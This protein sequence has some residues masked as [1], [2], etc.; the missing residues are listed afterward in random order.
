[1]RF[2][3]DSWKLHRSHYGSFS[4]PL[5]QAK[6]LILPGRRPYT[7]S[8]ASWI[9]KSPRF[10]NPRTAYKSCF[11][12]RNFN[13]SFLNVWVVAVPF[14]CP[15]YMSLD[16][17]FYVCG[18]HG[19]VMKSAGNSSS[20]SFL[21]FPYV[22]HCKRMVTFLLPLVYFYPRPLTFGDLNRV[23]FQGKGM[24]ACAKFVLVRRGGTSVKGT[25]AE[26]WL[27][28]YGARWREACD[29][30]PCEHG[31]VSLVFMANKA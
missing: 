24:L 18:R 28:A 4:M 10:S 17:D 1:M 23:N 12:S 30:A 8:S 26:W 27:I 29:I 13:N 19:Y 5:S 25:P 11:M 15:C 16:L 6:M 31:D 3:R 14:G 22:F 7:R 21:S 2:Q 20:S 9:V